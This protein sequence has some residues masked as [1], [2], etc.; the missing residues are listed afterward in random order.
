[1][2]GPQAAR[3]RWAPRHWAG[4]RSSRTV[5]GMLQLGGRACGPAPTLEQYR[6]RRQ[7]ALLGGERCAGLWVCDG[8][9]LGK[10]LSHL[11]RSLP[12][13]APAMPMHRA[14]S[15]SLL[16]SGCCQ[17][18]RSTP[19]PCQTSSK[20]PLSSIEPGASQRPLQWAGFEVQPLAAPLPAQNG[21]KGTMQLP[22]CRRGV[23]CSGWPVTGQA[24]ARAL[25]KPW[26]G[27][28]L[29]RGARRRGNSQ[30]DSRARVLSEHFMQA[31]PSAR[32][33]LPQ[34]CAV[35]RCRRLRCAMVQ[36]GERF[37]GVLGGPPVC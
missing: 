13:R 17:R 34:H 22:A 15:P 21:P 35:H 31:P 26:R 7:C 8:S 24:V 27:H 3:A 14:R 11:P 16:A 28:W 25:A 32:A 23:A 4:Q 10:P 29:S 20:A 5:S 1:M 19:R 6:A 30:L 9:A 18:T 12:S 2:P 36:D 33:A 37:S